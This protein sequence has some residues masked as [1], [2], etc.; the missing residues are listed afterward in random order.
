MAH[1]SAPTRRHSA[2]LLLAALAAAA[3]TPESQGPTASVAA[4]PPGDPSG[5]PNYVDPLQGL[6]NRP[7]SSVPRDVPVGFGRDTLLTR[8]E[9]AALDL[10]TA[11]TSAVGYRDI[12][13]A[14]V[15]G[16]NFEALQNYFD[17]RIKKSSQLSSDLDPKKTVKRVVEVVSR[18]YQFGF[19]V[20]DDIATAKK[21]KKQLTMVV[22]I[23]AMLGGFKGSDVA[24]IDVIVFVDRFDGRYQPV[25]RIL[26]EGRGNG[27]QAALGEALRQF[28]E[29]A[30]LYLT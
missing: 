14:I 7:A 17:A 24:Q 22:D 18:R 13:G 6:F 28:S 16:A 1:G 25:S 29:K 5:A 15:P 19:D 23:R 30:Q 20:V 21:E 12:F 2:G 10:M 26:A 3:C 4:V 27:F 8:A 9:A 11:E